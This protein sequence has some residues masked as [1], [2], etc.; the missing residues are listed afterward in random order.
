ME[1]TGTH[2]TGT[3]CRRLSWTFHRTAPGGRELLQLVLRSLPEL[4]QAPDRALAAGDGLPLPLPCA[5]TAPTCCVDVA[6]VPLQP[7]TL[8]VIVAAQPSFALFIAPISWVYVK[9]N[10]FYITSNRCRCPLDL[11]RA[12]CVL[13]RESISFCPPILNWDSQVDTKVLSAFSQRGQAARVDLEISGLLTL[14]RN[15]LRR[16]DCAGLPA[17]RL[18]L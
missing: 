12:A 9:I 14:Q 8:V 7:Q 16:G 18:V 4:L 6:N 13:H 17:K 1:L 2:G 10:A 11:L 3:V 5:S 15:T